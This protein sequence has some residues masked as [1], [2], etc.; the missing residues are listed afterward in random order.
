MTHQSWTAEDVPDQHGRTAVITGANTGLGLEAA[1][2]LAQHGAAVVLACRTP[3]KA[4]DAA[5]RIRAVAPAS[6]VTTLRLDQA[7]LALIRDAAEQLRAE[8]E[9][10]DLLINN[11][12][13]LGSSERTVTADGFEATFATN[14]LGVFAF[15]GLV[16]DR[17][18]LVPDS[19]VVTLSSLTHRSAT[20]DFD[21]LQSQRRYRRNVAYSRSKLANLLF[22]YGL[23]RR[24][25][26]AGA[27][28]ISVAAHPG[29]SRTE[30]TRDL[31]PVARFL[32]GPRVEALTGWMMQD[33]AVGVLGTV[34]AAVDPNVRGVEYYGPPGLFGLT[35]YPVHVKSS[36]R[37]HDTTAQ[38]RLWQE[39]ERLTNISYPLMAGGR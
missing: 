14:H 4:A 17:L 22:T 6:T 34:R 7:S 28:T 32:Y 30:F 26:A 5:D 18:L 15:T 10:I 11:A 31:N 9:R 39:S 2:V 27:G 36:A 12:G 13:M 37:S 20:L 19:R 1:R 33:R 29:Q 23:Q 8:H 16:L 21:D 35:G 38:D 24:L 3:A 25:S